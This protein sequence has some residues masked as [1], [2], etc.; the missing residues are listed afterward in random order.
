[1][2]DPWEILSQQLAA[3]D[4]DSGIIPEKDLWIHFQTISLDIGRQGEFL[5]RS[6]G[7]PESEISII[8][9]D[10]SRNCREKNYQILKK[11]KELNG[12]EATYECLSAAFL[13]VGRKDLEEKYCKSTEKERK[14]SIGHLFNVNA[15]TAYAQF[16][17]LAD[18]LF[19]DLEEGASWGRVAAAISHP[20]RIALHFATDS[21]ED[22][23]P[24]VREWTSRY[25]DKHLSNW[26]EE[27]GGLDGFMDFHAKDKAR[28]C[29]QGTMCLLGPSCLYC[30]LESNDMCSKDV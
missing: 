22:L 5:G 10:Y 24:D 13:D 18:E 7:L 14:N 15:K 21:I 12:R 11:W 25:L 4:H 17:D 27:H 29:F 1:M 16:K 30:W 23:A 9:E 20:W 26:K 3:E 8:Q 19:R 28:E 6:L 2:S